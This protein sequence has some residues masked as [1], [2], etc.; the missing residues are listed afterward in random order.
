[1]TK[2]ILAPTQADADICN[3]VVVP[4]AGCHAGSGVHVT[5]PPDYVARITLAQDVPGCTYSHIE[6]DGSLLVV[7]RCIARLA[8]PAVVNALTVPQQ[9]E[10]VLL[11]TK[12]S[13]AVVV[14]S[15]AAIDSPL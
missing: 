8:T 13:T 3:L 4:V 9:A 1:V 5:I 10:A 15:V 7:D 2:Q 14:A 6:W 12:L 11:N